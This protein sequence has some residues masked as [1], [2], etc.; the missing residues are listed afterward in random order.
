MPAFNLGPYIDAA[1][2]AVGTYKCRYEGEH[3]V[4]TA[5]EGHEVILRDADPSHYNDRWTVFVV[6]AEHKAIKI[7]FAVNDLL[8]THKNRAGNEVPMVDATGELL[9]KMTPAQFTAKIVAVAK[10]IP[11]IKLDGRN[12][13]QDMKVPPRFADDAM[14]PKPDPFDLVLLNPDKPTETE[15]VDLIEE[16]VNV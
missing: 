12:K 7:N 16:P 9:F 6:G 13:W 1:R 8:Q 15:A 11:P 4:Q 14:V 2:S 10:R 5:I 3:M